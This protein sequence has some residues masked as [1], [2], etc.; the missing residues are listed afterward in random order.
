[1]LISAADIAYLETLPL[2]VIASPESGGLGLKS[3]AVGTLLLFGGIP[4]IVS[5]LLFPKI[6][7][8]FSDK[9]VIWRIFVSVLMCTLVLTPLSSAFPMPMLWLVIIL[10]TRSFASAICFSLVFLLIGR[11]SSPGTT[12]AM[13]GIA[14][15]CA[16]ATRTVVPFVAAPL[17]A[18]SIAG[19]RMFP[20][21]YVLVFLLSGT[22]CA[23]SIY[24]SLKLRPQFQPLPMD[25]GGA[26]EMSRPAS[27]RRLVV[28]EVMFNDEL[29]FITSDAEPGQHDV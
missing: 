27:H 4:C 18:W 3:E 17:F 19:H 16:S 14:Q 13:N 24:F 23:V 22:P 26:E 1:M 28:G 6:C 20:L 2:W 21:N 5:N 15:S 7:G 11:T 29:D 25:A 12:G 8:I 10:V 9:M